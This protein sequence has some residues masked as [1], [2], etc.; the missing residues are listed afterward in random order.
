ME[1]EESEPV[2][3]MEPVT[4]D[5]N[6][7]DFGG[8]SELESIYKKLGEIEDKYGGIVVGE[9]ELKPPVLDFNVSF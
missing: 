4:N 7:Y 8:D 6:E 3:S 2:S 1:I 5:E 9:N